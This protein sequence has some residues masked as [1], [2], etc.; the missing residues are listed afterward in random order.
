MRNLLGRLHARKTTSLVHIA[1][2]WRIP[3]QGS[4]AG[5]HVGALYRVMTDIRAVRDAWSRLDETGQ[6]VVRTLSAAQSTARTIPELASDLD[7][8]EETIRDACVQ[9][10]HWG[11]LAREGDEQELPVGATPKL[12]VPREL[13]LDFRRVLDE[14]DAGDQSTLPLRTL[15]ELRD[16]ADIEESAQRWGI[17]VI[18]GLRRRHDLITEMLRQVNSTRRIDTVIAALGPAATSL[19]EIVRAEAEIGPLRLTEAIERAGLTVQEA[20]EGLAITQGA[21]LRDALTELESSLLV[22]HTYLK[23]GSRALFVPQE[24]LNPGTVP[25]AVPLRPLQPL[26]GDI[27][28]PEQRHPAAIAWDVLTMVREI[29]SKGAP[30]WVP[31]EPV[32]R[33]WQRQLNSRLWLQGEEVPPE[34]YLGFLLYLALGVGVLE[35]GSHGPGTGGDKNA[36]RPVPTPRV[37]QWRGRGFAHHIAALRDVWLYADQWVEGRERGQIDVWGADWQGFRR[38][39]LGDLGEIDP[40]EWFL[41]T[42]VARRL[43]EQDTGIVGST[44]TAASSRSGEERGDAR[45]AVIAQIIE[46]E[47]QTAMWWFGFVDLVRLGRKGLAMRV[48]EAAR[49]AASDS[50]E[51]VAAD[52]ATPEGKTI[53]IDATGLITLRHPEPVHVWS[54]TAFADAESLTPDVTYQLRPG[55]VGRALGAGFDLSQ[56]TLYLERQSGLPL[57]DELLALL[58]DWTAGYKRVRLRRV[59]LLTPDVE[60]GLDHLREVVTKAG[61]EVIGEPDGALLVMLPATGDDG[62]SA[63]D[64]LLKTLRHSGYAGQWYIERSPD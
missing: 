55:S 49:L 58:R 17:R 37:R 62:A 13:G 8:P 64:A 56:I 35:P 7:L 41:L 27:P 38:R 51:V 21:K 3:L 12:F 34:G 47:L 53:E 52:Q 16:D 32:S 1:R 20:P 43:A 4:D 39:L 24:I 2:L 15:L 18:P 50:R 25:T 61:L 10:F 36:I 5:R 29:T 22:H 63:E 54:L 19:W 11:I 33:T 26:S 31:G 57:P 6:R 30:V 60:K 42:D 14:I 46:L 44:F 23:D 59:A 45:V 40:H 28:E 48:T 9:L